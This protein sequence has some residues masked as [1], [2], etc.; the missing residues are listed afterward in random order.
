MWRGCGQVPAPL[1]VGGAG[2]APSKRSLR[3]SIGSVGYLLLLFII[4]PVA[5]LLLLIEIGQH[6]GSLTT[7]GII[8]ATGIL[9]ASL[10]RQQGLRTLARLRQELDHG[11][12]PTD[13]IADGVLILVAAAVLITPGVLT[14][15]FGFL[16]L[17]PTC[18][19]LMKRYLK[20]WFQHA[21]RTG[22]VR[23]NVA[24]GGR[25]DRTRHEP[26]KNVTPPR[27]DSSSN[28]S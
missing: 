17:I 28:G 27:P 14:D 15:L 18:R 19:Q 20:R 9:G 13:P 4:V 6:V 21:V 23:V 26:M 11:R 1:G 10:A 16:C 8:M 2:V 25:A 12:I 24:P 3:Q 22:S 5:E 7:V